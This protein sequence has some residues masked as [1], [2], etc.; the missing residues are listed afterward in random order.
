MFRSYLQFPEG[1]GGPAPAGTQ[2]SG[3]I[4]QGRLLGAWSVVAVSP[5]CLLP[6]ASHPPPCSEHPRGLGRGRRLLPG[7]DDCVGGVLLVRD[8]SNKQGVGQLLLSRLKLDNKWKQYFHHQCVISWPSSKT[9]CLLLAR[10]LTHCN[11]CVL[12]ARTRP[13][14]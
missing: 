13:E 12:L 11:S 14:D 10:W 9:D 2:G 7:W 4:Q 3:T 5:L 1:W 6:S 8:G